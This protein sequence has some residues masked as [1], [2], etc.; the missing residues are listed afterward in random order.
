MKRLP[1]SIALGLSLLVVPTSKAESFIYIG[2][3]GTATSPVTG[4]WDNDAH[5]FDGIN[6]V[7][8]LDT[9]IV[10]GGS[11]SDSYTATNNFG[12]FNLNQLTLES[13]SS[14]LVTVTGGTLNFLTNTALATPR[15]TQNGTGAAT[16]ASALSLTNLL[17]I[18]GTGTGL[19][20]L[21]GV[22]SGAGGLTLNGV[23]TTVL[24]NTNTMTGVVTL[25]SGTLRATGGNSAL[26][27]GAATLSLGGGNLEISNDTALN[28]GRATTVTGN[29]TVTTNRATAGA[30]IAHTLGAV[31]LNSG[32]KLTAAGGSN[33]T[34]GT[35]GLTLGAITLNGSATLEAT[36]PL[37]GGSTLISSSA[38]TSLGA[39]TLTVQ[40][41][42]NTTLSGVVSGTGGITKSG[43]GLLTL[44][45]ATAN[46]YTGLT[47]VSGGQLVL[48]KST[49]INA[50]VGNVTVGNGTISLTNANQIADTSTVTITDG[51]SFNLNAQSETISSLAISSS[52]TTSTVNLGN[53]LGSAALTLG[54]NLTLGDNTALIGGGTV[55]RTGGNLV[56]NLNGGQVSGD[57]ISIGSLDAGTI[58]NITKN[59]GNGSGT[60]SLGSSGAITTGT[61]NLNQTG[62]INLGTKIIA[63]SNASGSTSNVLNINV[64]N[65]A[66][67]MSGGIITTALLADIANPAGPNRIYNSANNQLTFA[68]GG[69]GFTLSGGVL[70]VRSTVTTGGTLTTA[71][72]ITTN[73]NAL[74]IAGGSLLGNRLVGTSGAIT[75][76]SGALI[77]RDTRAASADHFTI[78]TTDGSNGRTI[79]M[80]SGN[81]G[82]FSV[83]NVTNTTNYIAIGAQSSGG[84]W[85]RGTLN[86]GQNYTITADTTGT[87]AFGSAFTSY[88]IGANSGLNGL[89]LGATALPTQLTLGAN[90]SFFVSTSTAATRTFNVGASGGGNDIIAPTT[91]NFA[92]GVNNQ[93]N[94]QTINLNQD[95]GAYDVTL[96]A[97]GTHAGNAINLAANQTGSGNLYVATKTLTLNSGVTF[98]GTGGIFTDLVSGDGA[99]QNVLGG[100]IVNVTGSA[101]VPLVFNINGTLNGTNT[102][103]LNQDNSANAGSFVI[104]SGAVI[105]GTQNW[106]GA[107]TIGGANTAVF[108]NNLTTPANWTG[109][110]SLGNAGSG[111]TFEASTSTASPSTSG[112]YKFASLSLLP[113]GSAPTGSYRLVNNVQ[114]DGGT[115]KEAFYTSSFSAGGGIG[116]G[117]NGRYIFNL[118]GQDLYVDRFSNITGLQ[119]K[120]L[121]WQ[122]DALNSVSQIRALDV[123]GDTFTSGSFA[124]LNGASIEVVGGNY[125]AIV[126]NRHT[127]TIISDNA[128]VPNAPTSATDTTVK[129]T[130][131]WDGTSQAVGG[132]TSFLGSGTERG[133][134]SNSNAMGTNGTFRVIGGNFASSGYILNALGTTGTLD[135]TGTGDTTLNTVKIRG[136]A[137]QSITGTNGSSWLTLGTEQIYAVGDRVQVAGSATGFSITT[138]YYVTEVSGNQIRL[139]LTQGGTP[140]SATG[141]ITS[142]TATDPGGAGNNTTFPALVVAGTTNI[143]GHLVLANAPGATNQATL[144]VGGVT[145]SAS[146]VASGTATLNVTGDLTTGSTNNVAIQSNATVKVGGNV[147]IAGVGANLANNVTGTGVGINAASHFTL[148]GNKGTSTPQTVNIT[149]TVGNFHVGDGSA[150]TLTGTAAQARLTANLTSASGVDI[151]GSASSLNLGGFNLTANGTGLK[152]GGALLGTGTVAGATNV[153]SGGAIHSA[154]TVGLLTFSNAV[155]LDTG[156]AVN[157]AING[158]TTRGTD[159]SGAN[160]N[161]TLTISGGTLTFNFGSTLADAAVLNIFDGAALTSTFTSVVASGSYSGGFTLNGEQTAYTAIFGEQTVTFDLA[162]GSLSFTGSAVPEPATYAT[163]AALGALGLA[164]T[165]R[166][167]RRV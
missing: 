84:T 97:N 82:T 56:L 128:A 100:G 54:S 116:D 15:L 118:N 107:Q 114:N 67:G 166:R 102:I 110:I 45:G 6:V 151:N 80:L 1:Y 86:A 40:G 37:S 71:G 141:N 83:A 123:Q 99:V 95:K 78:S 57:P 98:G 2:P 162:S 25:T 5:W 48:A 62:S 109:S 148:N 12:S 74:T 42:G 96:L 23:G 155:T 126:Y 145:A 91:G 43:S 138:I 13:T 157:I 32:T 106:W 133:T 22:L 31:T 14:G 124:V 140:V 44:S 76:S 34:S 19:L 58:I 136:N 66:T 4:N 152:I 134:N 39:N 112:N 81:T 158:A 94:A 29:S 30:G 52:G 18:D 50:I 33:I 117:S 143:V 59:A 17:T 146:P 75:L 51:G 127:G 93:T 61:V 26:G 150:G 120:A 41:N 142:A 46:T 164:A 115:G 108:A 89:A 105:G 149:P 28:L 27:T 55:R 111:G 87:S 119:G 21:T 165:R 65:T 79:K 104:G 130:Q 63:Q 36:N 20:S 24:S 131:G 85:D 135:T 7:S 49:A 163:L 69:S 68:S 38:N 72:S 144:R 8:S 161:S 137:S 73:G 16:L 147:A 9:G 11:G 90:S 154:S 113:N 35:A 129:Q 88:T 156:S 132:F 3:A 139:S 122:N 92:F 160:F 103:S 101:T 70:D 47:T 125:N 167:S 64:A 77:L 53:Q 121:V 10:F 153:L 159:Y 60:L